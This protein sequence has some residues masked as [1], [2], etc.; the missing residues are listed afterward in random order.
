M[1]VRVPAALAPLFAL[2]LGCASAGAGGADRTA[3]AAAPPAARAAT[4]E[5]V[6]SAGAGDAAPA[7]SPPA[8]ARR[9]ATDAA[10]ESC[11]GLSEGPLVHLTVLATNDLHGALESKTYP[12][13]QAGR[14]VGGAATLAAFIERERAANP[15][16]TLLLDGGDLMQG[17][18]ISNLTRGESAIAYFNAAGYDAAAIGNHEFD[19][20]ID[21]LEQRMAQARFPLLS[22][23]IVRKA[24]GARPVWAVP[25]ATLRRKGLTIGIVGLTTRST[26]TTTLPA[27]VADLRFTDLAQAVRTEAARLEG[28]GADLVV[29]LAHA[30]GTFDPASHTFSGE[31][32]DAMRRMPPSVGLVV[33]GHTH[34]LLEGRVAGIPL[35]Q[36]RSR[37]TALAVVQLW[38]DPLERRVVCSESRVETTYGDLVQPDSAMAA[39]VARYD[40]TIDPIAQR[41]VAQA[42]H[43]LTADRRRESVLGDLVADAQRAATGT[44]IAL[45]NSGGIRA[46][47]DA[48]PIRWSE[49]LEAQPFEN[50]LHRLR[51]TGRTLR[52][53]LENGVRGDYGLVQVSGVRFTVDPRAP[54]GRRVSDLR[55][56]DGGPIR[57]DSTYTVTV[58][59][60]MSQGGDG[61]TML[62][63]A[64]ANEDTGII[65]LDAFIHHLESLPQPIR[66]PLQGRI[67]FLGDTGGVRDAR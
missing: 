13:S 15:A 16:G 55:L 30:G 50:P 49:A 7:T 36:A 40:A 39:L 24:D 67:R 10:S 29:V 11:A 54:A 57:P 61:Y 23:N 53:A 47:I 1:T 18:A 17:T 66:Y 4:G 63:N 20:G 45:T 28:A 32:V 35:V 26:P 42:A 12:W 22:A 3:G 6:D 64:A 21:V 44:Q 27:Q 46:E 52:E 31:I 37:G 62:E 25:T 56:E 38:V 43:R 48:G 19:W 59:N 8:E 34:T 60:F 58:N 14:P 33:S 65:D 51:I 9:A 2:W 41:V 5:V